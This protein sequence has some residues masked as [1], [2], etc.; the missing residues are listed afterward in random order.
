MVDG[1]QCALLFFDPQ[2]TADGIVVAVYPQ[3]S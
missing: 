1:A 3:V 2:V